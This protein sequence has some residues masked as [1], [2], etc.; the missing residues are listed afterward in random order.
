MS[1]VEF[2]KPIVI[3]ESFRPQVSPLEGLIRSH[4]SKCCCKDAGEVGIFV[5]LSSISCEI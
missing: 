5:R 1:L 3:L 4:A 2:R